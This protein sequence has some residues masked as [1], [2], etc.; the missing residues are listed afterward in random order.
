MMDPRG[1]LATF[2]DYLAAMDAP[3]VR[4]F[5]AGF[6]L[7]LPSRQ[8]AAAD[9]PVIERLHS[10]ETGRGDVLLESL[11]RYAPDLHWAR[12]YT[13]ADFGNHF[14]QNYGW[15]EMFGSRGHFVSDEMAG[16]F[17]VLGSGIDY[18]DH[19][20]A[21]E[22]IYIPLTDGSL[23]SKD[24]GA[25]TGRNAGEVI[26]HPSGVNHAMKTKDR[27]LVALYLWRGGPLSEKPKFQGDTP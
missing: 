4:R 14:L 22:E 27:L 24:R 1:L 25:F 9:I 5:I 16:G 6:D 18:P 23:W 20:H 19:H 11:L 17:L 21:A 2:R 15:V 3:E 26:H 7:D 10:I 12:T 13:S 8:L